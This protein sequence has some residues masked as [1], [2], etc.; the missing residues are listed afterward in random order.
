MPVRIIKQTL[1]HY[2]A[3]LLIEVLI[4]VMASVRVFDN[5]PFLNTSKMIDDIATAMIAYS[6]AVTPRLSALN[7]LRILRSLELIFKSM[8]TSIYSN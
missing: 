4:A 5:V 2:F 3:A 8:F 1:F 7:L 6:T